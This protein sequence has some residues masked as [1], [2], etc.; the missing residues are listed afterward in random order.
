[1]AGPDG[2]PGGGGDPGNSRKPQKSTRQAVKVPLQVPRRLVQ[3]GYSGAFQGSKSGALESSFTGSEGGGDGENEGLE[4]TGATD[5]MST[6]MLSAGM[7]AGGPLPP[8]LEGMSQM[9]ES[10]SAKQGGAMR[11]LNNIYP[12]EKL[13]NNGK[14][15]VKPS[16]LHFGGLKIHE[17]HSQTFRI[18]NVSD[19]SIRVVVL[20]P[21]TKY[22]KIK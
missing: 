3:K 17:E 16:V 19:T 8:A 15:V 12:F 7:Q 11:S 14:V 13:D 10:I 2:P 9:G 6:M 18:I 20:P 1:M 5:K 21:E 22:F 4:F